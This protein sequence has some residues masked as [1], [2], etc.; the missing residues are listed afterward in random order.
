MQK[1]RVLAVDDEPDILTVIRK[2]LDGATYT[3]ETATDATRAWEMLNRPDDPFDFMILDRMLPCLDG[4]D[5]LRMVKK[6]SRLAALP[7]IMQSAASMPEQI[8]EGIEAGAFYYLTKPWVPSALQCIVRSVI[9]DIALRAKVSSQPTT[10]LVLLKYMDSGQLSFATLEDI[11]LLAGLLSAICPDPDQVAGGLAE[12]LL[13]AVEHGNLGISYLEKKELMYEDRWEDEVR[14]RLALPE[15]RKRFATVSFRRREGAVEFRITDQGEGFDW[16]R[17]L[18]LD[19]E[20][21]VD[22]NGRGI[23]MARRY[24]FTGVEYQGAGNTVVASVAW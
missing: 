22:P 6:D 20:R 15:N 7:V 24:A 4:L 1:W 13:N 19:P 2:M 23:A 17:Y 18:E 11:S 3:V 21:L 10:D 5:L 16:S 9:S 12:L 8:A 14:R